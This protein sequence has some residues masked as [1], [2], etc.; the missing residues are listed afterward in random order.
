MVERYASVQRV[1]I[2]NTKVSAAF[3]D[4]APVELQV[5]QTWEKGTFF[6]RSPNSKLFLCLHIFQLGDYAC[7]EILNDRMVAKA[8]TRTSI[9]EFY[10]YYNWSAHPKARPPIQ[11]TGMLEKLPVQSSMDSYKDLKI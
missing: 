11:P 3:S 10:H 6:H 1:Y 4:P 8:I 5:W 9:Q 7:V 2:S